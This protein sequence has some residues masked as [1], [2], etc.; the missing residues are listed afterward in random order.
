MFNESLAA[1][2][3]TLTAELEALPAL[4]GVFTQAASGAALAGAYI[5]PDATTA[6]QFTQNVI[7]DPCR[8]YGFACCNDTFGT[9]EF[10]TPAGLLAADGSPLDPETSRRPDDEIVIDEQCTGACGRVCCGVGGRH[11]GR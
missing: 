5:A 10:L 3:A 9:P 7:F 8:Y 1:A 6:G 4:S 11:V 2:D